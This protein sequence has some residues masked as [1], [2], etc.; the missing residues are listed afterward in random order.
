MSYVIPQDLKKLPPVWQ[1]WGLKDR[2]KMMRELPDYP[3]DIKFFATIITLVEQPNKVPNGN[4]CGVM[5]QG[6]KKPWGWNP[7]YWERV[8]PTGCVL[9][10]EGM[11]G[12]LAPFLAFA[13][14]EDSF[15]FLCEVVLRRQINSPREYCIQWV[16]MR[17][18]KK[19][20]MDAFQAKVRLLLNNL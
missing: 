4:C 6:S 8:E 15:R 16:G 1:N 3:I 11:T 5:C 7:V 19:E 10:K 18:P 20:I 14:I 2:I 9:L 13:K 17:Q 12:K